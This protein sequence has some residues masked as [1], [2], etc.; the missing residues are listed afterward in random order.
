MVNCFMKLTFHGGAKSVTG[1]NYLLEHNNKKILVDCGLFQGSKYA[2]TFNYEKFPYS[3]AE[4]DVLVITHSHT[5]HVGRVP[6]LYKDGFK[7]K[8]IATNPAIDLMKEALANSTGLLADEARRNGHEPI[9]NMKDTNGAMELMEGHHYKEDID[10]GNDLVV[11]LHDAG[12]ILGS[13]IVEIRWKTDGGEDRKIYFSG[14]LGNPPTP[15]LNDPFFPNDGDYAVMESTYSTYK[16]NPKP[17]RGEVSVS[18]TICDPAKTTITKKILKVIDD[19]L[20]NLVMTSE[21][22]ISIA[23]KKNKSLIV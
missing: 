6:K 5:D 18:K 4:I 2:E 1:A 7:G 21:N 23:T 8:I 12:H 20:L 16:A 19:A 17:I 3:P 15:L 10:L 11:R 22:M 9:F 14:D 13:S